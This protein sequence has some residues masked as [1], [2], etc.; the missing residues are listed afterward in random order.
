MSI[1]QAVALADLILC[2]AAR[3]IPFI[4]AAVAV[5]VMLYFTRKD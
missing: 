4:L 3:V 2:Y 5:I 1:P